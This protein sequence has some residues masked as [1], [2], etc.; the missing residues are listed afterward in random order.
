MI[1][2]FHDN[3]T[4]TGRWAG[5]KCEKPICVKDYNMTMAG[6]D[7]KD[8]KLSMNLM[9]RQRGPRIRKNCVD[10][11]SKNDDTLIS[12]IVGGEKTTIEEHPYQVAIRANRDFCG[13]FIISNTYILT[14]AHCLGKVNASDLIMR[15]GSTFRNNGSKI[16]V[17]EIIVHPDYNKK[18]Y[19]KDIGII[20][21]TDPIS[22]NKK[23]HPIP[24]P[25]RKRALLPGAEIIISGWGRTTETADNIP[26]Q[27]REVTIQVVNFTLCRKVYGNILTENMFCAGDYENGGKGSCRGDSGGAAIQKELAVGIVSFAKGCARK[28]TPGVF[29]DIAAPD[30]RDFITKQTHL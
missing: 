26:H 14:A 28:K 22:F 15:A 24:L 13:G 12:R 11:A 18:R 16:S 21:T 2:T 30:I 5:E 19:D 9:E 3:S 29:V 20:R 4:Y 17:A 6:I 10:V 7:L 27:L 1:S 8:Q 25:R 23:I